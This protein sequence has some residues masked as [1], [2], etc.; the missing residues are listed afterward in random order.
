M[1]FS[2]L[3]R[4]ITGFLEV[5]VWNRFV[6]FWVNAV[7][8]STALLLDLHQSGILQ[9]PQG[10]DRF[11]PSAVE[12]LHYLVDGIVEVNAPIFI[13]P[14]VFP[15]QVCP[16]QDKGIQYLCFV[17]Q[18]CECGGF[19]KEIRKPGKADRLFRLMNINRA[20][21]SV[22]CGRLEARFPRKMILH[23][24]RP[25]Y[26]L[27]KPDKSRLFFC[28]TVHSRPPFPFTFCFL[29]PVNS[30]GAVGAVFSPVGFGDEHTAA[31]R[32]AFQVL[33]PENL[34]FQ[35]SDL[36]QD[37][38][39][40][41]LTADRERNGLGAGV[42]VPI[43]KEHTVPVLITAALPADQGVCLFPLCRCHAVKG[44]VLPALYGRQSFIWVLSHVFPPFFLSR[45]PRKGF[46]P[47]SCGVFRRWHA[48]RTSGHFV[49]K[50]LVAVLP[51]P[52]YS[53]SDGHSFF[54]VQF[55]D[56]LP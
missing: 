9:L 32:T 19:K 6:G 54:K 21:H 35:R 16:A 23:T 38:P 55:I 47:H 52:G 5:G 25:G 33:I 10:V 42:G 45:S 24:T 17:G 43:V 13:C 20:C 48:P 2:V 50:W 30:G 15:G 56:E 4:S 14:A 27:A 28:L 39:A 53:F 12:Q 40:E 49:P 31:D 51:L 34:C 26:E 7:G 41:P 11:L 1:R 18:G 44:T 46:L 36:R 22:F 3:R 37:R 8:F 29:P